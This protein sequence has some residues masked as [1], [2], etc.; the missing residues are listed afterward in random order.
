MGSE[1]ALIAHPGFLFPRSGLVLMPIPNST[2]DMAFRAFEQAGTPP[3]YD[4]G[5]GFVATLGHSDRTGV[6]YVNADTFQRL[7]SSLYAQGRN[8]STVTEVIESL[9]NVIQRAGETDSSGFNVIVQGAQS[10]AA[11]AGDELHARITGTPA[12]YFVDLPGIRPIP[13]NWP[14]GLVMAMMETLAKG[15]D[16][17]TGLN[18]TFDADDFLTPS[19]INLGG[20]DSAFSITD[21]GSVEYQTR[22]DWEAERARVELLPVATPAQIRTRN[23][24]FE[25][26]LGALIRAVKSSN[27]P[28]TI[29][30]GMGIAAAPINT[31]AVAS[32]QHDGAGIDSDWDSANHFLENMLARDVPALMPVVGGN[33]PVGQTLPITDFLTHVAHVG[34]LNA[35][36]QSASTQTLLRMGGLPITTQR[37]SVSPSAYQIMVDSVELSMKKYNYEPTKD[38]IYF[39]MILLYYSLRHMNLDTEVVGFM[40][41]V[42]DLVFQARN[43]S[44]NSFRRYMNARFPVVGGG[45]PVALDP[46]MVQNWLALQFAHEAFSDPTSEAF[47]ELTGVRLNPGV[48][49]NPPLDLVTDKGVK[50]IRDSI[51]LSLDNYSKA[52]SATGDNTQSEAVL[53]SLKTLIMPSLLKQMKTGE[54]KG[55]FIYA[56]NT[57][58]TEDKLVETVDALYKQ[59]YESV[60]R[61]IDTVNQLAE[62][63]AGNHY[64]IDR[65]TDIT[66]LLSEVKGTTVAL[67]ILDQSATMMDDFVKFMPKGTSSREKKYIQQIRDFMTIIGDEL[68]FDEERVADLIEEINKDK[69]NPYTAFPSGVIGDLIEELTQLRDIVAAYDTTLTEFKE[70]SMTSTMAQEKYTNASLPTHGPSGMK[71]KLIKAHNFLLN[72]I[73]QSPTLRDGYMNTYLNRKENIPIGPNANLFDDHMF[74]ARS[75]NP[76]IGALSIKPDPYFDEHVYK[77]LFEDSP[78]KGDDLLQFVKRQCDALGLSTSVENIESHLRMEIDE[79]VDTEYAI[80]EKNTKKGISAIK[81]KETWQGRRE[82]AAKGLRWTVEKGAAAPGAAAGLLKSATQ[83][84]YETTATYATSVSESAKT[85][86]EAMRF[87]GEEA[88]RQLRAASAKADK[89]LSRAIAREKAKTKDLK[90]ALSAL[91]KVKAGEYKEWQTRQ[92]ALAKMITSK[93]LSSYEAETPVGAFEAGAIAIG[94]LIQSIDYTRQRGRYS[95][96]VA[97]GFK[98][99]LANIKKLDSL[100]DSLSAFPS[101][102]SPEMGEVAHQMV[103]AI[104]LLQMQ[105]TNQLIRLRGMKRDAPNS[106]L[107]DLKNG[108]QHIANTF[109]ELMTRF[110]EG[111]RVGATRSKAMVET[112][113]A[114]AIDVLVYGAAFT[115]GLAKTVGKT[116]VAI[117]P[118]GIPLEIMKQN[119]LKEEADKLARRTAEA[120]AAK[121]RMLGRI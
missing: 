53:H 3:T 77:D 63:V 111:L 98:E 33:H 106:V 112:T 30:L 54:V 32:R 70:Y 9:V 90:N 108:S 52:V 120:E 87:S 41:R 42:S 75:S 10:M 11:L 26:L 79:L 50:D 105:T 117:T 116:A 18:G 19:G 5:T 114:A 69:D 89:E 76:T 84:G 25:G 103:E 94:S 24:L 45:A 107:E 47:A 74:N 83:V 118:L 49:A 17:I 7:G 27:L 113:A 109:N 15:R 72:I 60:E 101:E 85:L 92:V 28:F 56:G 39:T 38:D 14:Q 99:V 67:Q 95:K 73:Y 121:D 110:T 6:R 16:R 71:K 66:V 68:S 78:R 20:G 64:D 88:R 82:R 61:H 23:A 34:P 119:R 80:Y 8:Q 29:P 4:P 44:L 115:G 57:E 2:R 91:T 97:N 43:R 104:E 21:N 31:H 102:A 93:A 37:S 55:Q 58:T 35:W 62:K 48:R 51:K 96:G 59:C 36:L 13:T 40:T 22:A 46:A 100:K 12:F 65:R 81:R 86:R 1:F